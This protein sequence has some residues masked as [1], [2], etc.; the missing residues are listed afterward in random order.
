MS[1]PAPDPPCSHTTAA[2]V[3][4]LPTP[5]AVAAASFAKDEIPTDGQ[6]YLI[7]AAPI[8]LCTS[9]TTWYSSQLTS[10]PTRRI[11]EGSPRRHLSGRRAR[12]GRRRQT[13][14][15]AP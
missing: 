14:E 5:S 10:T 4:L 2:A 12:A 6:G 13:L 8:R 15:S 9:Q 1:A 11:W 3:R 7:D